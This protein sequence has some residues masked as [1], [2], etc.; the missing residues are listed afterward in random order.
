VMCFRGACAPH[1][2]VILRK[3]GDDPGTRPLPSRNSARDAPPRPV[4][5][6]RWCFGCF[7][8]L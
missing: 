7:E 6:G 4:V 8:D 1:G 3:L 2:M 5:F